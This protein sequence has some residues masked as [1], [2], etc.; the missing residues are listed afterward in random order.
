MA[1]AG[2]D[3]AVPFTADRREIAARG[4]PVRRDAHTRD[5]HCGV[6]AALREH[7]FADPTCI[8]IVVR[9]GRTL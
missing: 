6:V 4:Y 3:Q 1:S 8:P 7:S 9:L 5:D 2:F